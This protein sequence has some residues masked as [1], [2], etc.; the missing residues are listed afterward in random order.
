MRPLR[1]CIYGGTS[2]RGTPTDFISELAYQIL[3]SMSAV[4]VTGGFRYS[5]EKPEAISTDVAAL[6]GAKR[7]ARRKGASLQD[8]FE[9]WVPE[10]GMDDH[11]NAVRMTSASG[12]T[13]RVMTGLTALGR[14]LAMVGEVDLVVTIAGSRHTEVVG[15]QALELGL[16]VFPIPNAGGDSE[17]LLENYRPRVAASFHP[18]ALDECLSTLAQ[19]LPSDPK[20]AA[21][22]VVNLLKTAKIDRCL[23]LMPFDDLH[24][25]LYRRQVR[26]AV[27]RQMT[28][29]RLDHI[30]NSAAIY[31]SFAD[32]VRSC[33]AVI[34]DVTTLNGN[35][36]YEVG[37]AHGLGLTPLIYTRNKL[38]LSRL[39]V[40]FRTL[41]V[42]LASDASPVE[43]L[44]DEYLL[45]A[46]A[47]RG[48]RRG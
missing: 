14:R 8:C 27:E 11:R 23:V 29:I 41:N 32:A 44:I 42:R 28:A 25:E 9:A 47:R 26:P 2:L 37:Y 30:P 3:D 43:A 36:M 19:S 40:Y 15:E 38:R 10:P 39:P 31:T 35:V 1:V 7:Y 46:K 4:I 18:G 5:T 16:P 21:A 17:R 33:S 48:Q 12:M 45:D 22:A 6:R 34:A 20:I 24:N 13:V